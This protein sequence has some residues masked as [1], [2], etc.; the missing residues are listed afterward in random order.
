MRFPQEKHLVKAYIIQAF[1]KLFRVHAFIRHA[2]KLAI[3]VKRPDTPTYHPDKLFPSISGSRSEY[4]PSPCYLNL[5]LNFY[6]LNSLQQVI[7]HR[8]LITK[9]RHT[10]GVTLITLCQLQ[11]EKFPGR[12]SR[13]RSILA[14]LF[15]FI[16]SRSGGALARL[17][18]YHS[19]V[20]NEVTSY[21]LCR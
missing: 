20:S 3:P 1:A 21:Q 16:K 4:T 17:S 9:R 13:L 8:L 6:P 19:L 5:S 15:S 10:H 2:N 7:F 11:I 12:V 18:T 14:K